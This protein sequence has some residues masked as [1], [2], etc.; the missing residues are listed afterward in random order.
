MLKIW[1]S[2]IEKK[3]TKKSKNLDTMLE[4]KVRQYKSKDY[5]RIRGKIYNSFILEVC[6][7][8]ISIA[9]GVSH[10]GCRCVITT[11]VENTNCFLTLKCHSGDISDAGQK[12][13]KAA[14]QSP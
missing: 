3:S 5:D 1:I 8:N 11:I 13:R 2:V 7:A 10:L 6:L 12:T 14:V 9:L 4:K